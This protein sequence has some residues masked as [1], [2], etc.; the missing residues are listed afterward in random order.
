MNIMISPVKDMCGTPKNMCGTPM[1]QTSTAAG[2][3]PCTPFST[4]TL[5]PLELDVPPCL[6]GTLDQCGTS[7]GLLA[8]S[9]F[10]VD[11][12]ELA[13]PTLGLSYRRSKSVNDSDGAILG[14]TWGTAVEGIAH[15]DG[16]IQVGSHFLPTVLDGKR[17]LS[18]K[19][20]T[21]T[22]DLE[23]T[24]VAEAAEVAEDTE[25]S[26]EGPALTADGQVVDLDG[27]VPIFFSCA[28]E[29]SS[30]HAHKVDMMSDARVVRAMHLAHAA[31]DGEAAVTN[32]KKCSIDEWGIVHGA[33][34][35]APSESMEKSAL[36]RLHRKQNARQMS[37]KMATT[38]AD[39]TSILTVNG[40]GRIC[41]YLDLASKGPSKQRLRQK[42][43]ESRFRMDWGEEVLSVDS[44]GSVHY[45][46]E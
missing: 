10:L 11:N 15:T 20:R 16:W 31:C 43:A 36:K 12:S 39:E 22:I 38:S 7:A 8:K 1:S 42:H 32:E 13:A 18:T 21:L 35:L 4:F 24:E 37:S 46:D 23:V 30:G 14:P 17:V 41:L 6:F 40:A 34:A 19:L 2:S 3:A 9:T 28:K 26:W 44:C 25:A 27:G 33:E 5:E 29:L 45:S